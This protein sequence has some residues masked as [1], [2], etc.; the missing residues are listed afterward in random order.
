[1]HAK[2]IATTAAFTN[3]CFKLIN[4]KNESPL[5]FSSAQFFQHSEKGMEHTVSDE[6]STKL[7]I[8][9]YSCKIIIN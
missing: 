9:S 3:Q 8:G 4:A 5:T 7:T 6:N 2:Y 1:M